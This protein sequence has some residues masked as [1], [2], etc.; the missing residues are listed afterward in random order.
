MAE[1]PLNGSILTK[2]FLPAYSLQSFRC[3][4]I[5]TNDVTNECLVAKHHAKGDNNTGDCILIV[6][7]DSFPFLR[8]IYETLK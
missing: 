4:A 5:K 8:E 7:R 3:N 6:I 1:I 2:K